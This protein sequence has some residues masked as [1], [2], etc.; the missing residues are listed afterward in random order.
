MPT[1]Y[2]GEPIATFTFQVEESDFQEALFLELNFRSNMHRQEVKVGKNPCDT[3]NSFCGNDSDFLRK[4]QKFLDAD[5]CCR[6]CAW[7]FGAVLS[8]LAA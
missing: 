3:G 2:E 1:F 4:V 6:L 8:F 7:N 5:D